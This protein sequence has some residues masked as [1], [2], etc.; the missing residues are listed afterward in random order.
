M[1][2]SIN[3]SDIAGSEVV[4]LPQELFHAGSTPCVLYLLGTN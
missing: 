1:T 2:L 3:Y 4:V